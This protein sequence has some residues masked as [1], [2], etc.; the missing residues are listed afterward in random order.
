[1]ISS[2]SRPRFHSL[3]LMLVASCL[4]FQA[5]AAPLS[6][7]ALPADNRIKVLYYDPSDVYVIR[8]KY[9]YQTNIVFEQG[10]EIQTISMG[11]RSL[12]QIIPGDNRLYIR[13]MQENIS[14]NMT[15]ITNIRSYEFDLKSVDSKSEN[16]IYVA[17]FVYDKPNMDAPSPVEVP[18]PV[19]LTPPEPKSL[20]KLKAPEPKFEAPKFAPEPMPLKQ[21]GPVHPN[22]NYTYSG[23]DSLAPDK[24]YD[25]GKSTYITLSS[26]ARRYT[27]AVFV[28]RDDK[29]YPA[30]SKIQ[31]GQIIVDEVAS[32]L[33]LRSKTGAVRIYNELLSPR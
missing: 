27:P 19:V 14:T 16:N 31:G 26:S 10:E 1:M 18:A 20:G 33:I 21:S 5:E 28:V 7:G 30:P 29:E 11:D 13:P 32:A 22:Y 15:L 6:K 4:A 25:D 2:I 17:R 8:A 3:T 23:P 12:W 24:V 9:G